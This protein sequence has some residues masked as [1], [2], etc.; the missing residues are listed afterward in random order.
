M[1]IH[2]RTN[3]HTHILIGDLYIKFNMHAMWIVV[4]NVISLNWNHCDECGARVCERHDM[5]CRAVT[6]GSL[7]GSDKHQITWYIEI[8]RERQCIF[9]LFANMVF[10]KTLCYIMDTISCGM[11]DNG[12]NNPTAATLIKGTCQRTPF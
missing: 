2:K 11:I 9:D 5:L 12:S 7:V 1:H 3:T 10:R 8:E 4:S 6:F